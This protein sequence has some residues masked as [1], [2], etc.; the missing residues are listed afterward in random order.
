MSAPAR[1]YSSR[2]RLV[3]A[4]FACIVLIFGGIGLT[5]NLVARHE[6]EELF[7]ARLATSAWVSP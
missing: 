4:T 2:R 3:A 6:S 5:A 1:T 7:S